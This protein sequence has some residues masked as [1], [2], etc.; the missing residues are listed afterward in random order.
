MSVIIT[1]VRNITVLVSQNII[2]LGFFMPMS[3]S[4]SK[5]T[6]P[7]PPLTSF[8]PSRFSP[9]LFVVLQEIHDQPS[10][11]VIRLFAKDNA[12]LKKTRFFF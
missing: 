11:A 10:I 3:H 7:V 12:F 8:S 9:G 4:V 5:K 6:P 1:I 2:F